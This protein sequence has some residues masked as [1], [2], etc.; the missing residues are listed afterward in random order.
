MISGQIRGPDGRPAAG[1]RVGVSG[2]LEDACRR[3]AAVTTTDANGRFR[4]DNTR[5]EHRFVVLLPIEKF[6]QPYTICGGSDSSALMPAYEGRMPARWD[7]AP[8]DSVSCFSWLWRSGTRVTCTSLSLKEAR[9]GCSQCKSVLTGG[10]WVDGQRQG[11][12]RIVSTF[13]ES[14]TRRPQLF[15]QWMRDSSV[16]TTMEVTPLTSMDAL[17]DPSLTLDTNGWSLVAT[18][19]KGSDI[20]RT[21]TFALGPPDSVRLVRP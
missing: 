13:A 10:S 15:V 7:G 17:V 16:V 4:L 5:L 18:G 20:Q 1:L 21:L 2:S 9:T 8:D 6:V 3:P 12:Y 11:T 19:V 14:G